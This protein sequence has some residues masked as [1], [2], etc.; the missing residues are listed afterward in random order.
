MLRV[1][2]KKPFKTVALPPSFIQCEIDGPFWSSNSNYFQ[3]IEM[4]DE[5]RGSYLVLFGRN[6]LVWLDISLWTK[7]EKINAN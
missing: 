3:S 5:S 6:Y 1:Q 4:S 2:P 7:N